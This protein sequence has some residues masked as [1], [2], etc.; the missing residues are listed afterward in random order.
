MK[1]AEELLR[2]LEY[3]SVDNYSA[4]INGYCVANH[5]SEAFKLFVRLSKLGV[6]IKKMF[7]C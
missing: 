1:E 5:T 6:L 3:D 4:K 2:S 7:M